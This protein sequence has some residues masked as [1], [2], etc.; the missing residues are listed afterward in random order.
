MQSKLMRE[1][2]RQKDAPASINSTSLRAAIDMV[3]E[4]DGAWLKNACHW[5]DSRAFASFQGKARF[6]EV[7][8]HA[9]GIKPGA[10]SKPKTQ[11]KAPRPAGEWESLSLRQIDWSEKQ[12]NLDQVVN[13]STGI[14]LANWDSLRG[15]ASKV[16][17]AGYLALLVPGHFSVRSDDDSALDRLQWSHQ[18]IVVTDRLTLQPSTRKAT[19]FQLGEKKVTKVI[20]TDVG[21][22]IQG[23]ALKEVLCVAVLEFLTPSK[24][25]EAKEDAF[26][27]FR[28]LFNIEEGT[29]M[30]GLRTKD[31]HIEVI[32]KVKTKIATD[33]ILSQKKLNSQGIFAREILRDNAK[34]DDSTSII[35]L[36]QFDN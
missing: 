33:Y 36:K 26:L 12:I 31:T 9:L 10:K 22:G 24:A 34:P 14:A 16:S 6:Y 35:W 7:D 2:R 19:L 29:P 4:K 3:A 5:Q 17:S 1:L 15:L 28:R 18:S 13:D 30:Y 25:K 32:T 20:D 23:D 11:T 21:I 27:F 8:L